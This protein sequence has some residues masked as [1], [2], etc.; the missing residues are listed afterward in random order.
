MIILKE[1]LFANTFSFWD[2]LSDSE[3]DSFIYGSIDIAYTKGQ[4]IHRSS[5]ECQGAIIVLSGSM[6]I[7]IVSEEGREV[8][9]FRI[10]AGDSCVLSVSCLLETIEF[11]I[12]I[13]SV[14]DVRAVMIPT[15]VLFPIM[16][17]NPYV[18]LYMYKKATERFSDV[19]WIMQQILFMGIDKRVAIFLWNEMLRQKQ[20]VLKVTHDEIAKNISSAREVVTKVLKY[21]AEDGIILLNRGKIEIINKSKLQKYL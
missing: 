8:T 10:Y 15:A 14:G 2:R 11:E 16:K 21:F 19:M 20:P 9:L 18:E 3:K 13:E 17:N 6:R 4:I 7:Y 5:M 1:T 12:I